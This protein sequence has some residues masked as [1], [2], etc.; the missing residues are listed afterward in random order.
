MLSYL[1][2]VR[3]NGWALG[4]GVLHAFF[5]A[6]GQTV[7]IAI[8]VTAIS[9]DLGIAPDTFGFAY[10]VATIGAALGLVL[11]GHHMDR[12]SLRLYVAT[13]SIGLAAACFLMASANGAVVLCLGLL[14]LRS[15]G[16]VMSHIEGT[17]TARAF[18]ANRG[19]ALGVTA[20]GM[21]VAEAVLPI[22][23]VLLLGIVGWRISHVTIG[24]AAVLILLP[25][26]QFML[27]RFDARPGKE[28][29]PEIVPRFRDGAGNLIRSPYFWAVLPCLLVV[30]FAAT[31]FMF[32]L[33]GM[34]AERG[35]SPE[36]VALSFSALAVANAIGLV[37]SGP[38]IDNFS[39]R[40]LLPLHTLPL[41]AAF[42]LFS[43]GSSP[44]VLP[45]ALAL[46]GFGN[47]LMRTLANA[48]WAEVYGTSSLGAIRSLVSMLKIFAG[49]I[50]P[51]SLGFLLS[52]GLSSS[53]AVLVLAGG[54]ALASAT[55]VFAYRLPRRA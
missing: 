6:P 3:K 7:I 48:V 47:G 22:L 10:M 54:G 24:V 2:F 20:L 32:H 9:K 53:E 27:G 15:G 37:V 39:A 43:L 34:S 31:A 35:W 52:E 50:G 16:I 18:H 17:A 23:L 38:L 12:V 40:A 25:L 46:I 5:A 28:H 55:V 42:V 41:L 19:K 8:F 51:L 11:V 14:A 30:P 45:I 33:Y 1:R 49:G 26:G 44:F 21:P 4:F 36:L 29:D 13:A